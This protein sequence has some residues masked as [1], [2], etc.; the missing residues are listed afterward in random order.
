M[1]AYSTDGGQRFSANQRIS[2]AVSCPPP[3]R[4]P[5]AYVHNLSPYDDPNRPP[6]SVANR[7]TTLQRTATLGPDFVR[8]ARNEANKSLTNGRIIVSFD[9]SRNL[10][11]GHY[12]GLAS[13]RN[14]TFAAVWADRRSGR[15]EL[16]GARITLA[17]PAPPPA[18]LA[19]ADVTNRVE[20]VTEAPVYDAAKSTVRLRLQVRN[21]SQQ[22]VYGPVRLE[23][24]GILNAAGQPT[25]ERVD[26][27]GTAV[28][29]PDVSFAGKLGSPDMLVPRE[30]SESV[31]IVLKLKPDVGFD[32]AVD[33][34]VKG[35]V[36]R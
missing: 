22:P 28:T 26:S 34:R 8:R 27:A 21:V 31:E 5:E 24:V 29:S 7:L 11:A 1:F 18:N 25:A 36:A 9:G 6:D 4:G 10:F 32:T 23:I 2:S 20:V 15:Q 12:T 14:G 3:Q 19:D 17:P 16:Y 30:V 13:D 33:F 35:R